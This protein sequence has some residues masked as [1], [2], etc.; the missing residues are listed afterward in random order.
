[1]SFVLSFVSAYIFRSMAM[2]IVSMVFTIA[3]RSILAELYLSKLMGVNIIIMLMQEIVTAGI[4]MAATWFL[5]EK[6]AFSIIV[7]TYILFI[8]INR[9]FINLQYF[10]EV[11]KGFNDNE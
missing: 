6:I 1:M 5:D 7:C 10:L 4:F 3:F 11:I 9:K 8:M 2:V